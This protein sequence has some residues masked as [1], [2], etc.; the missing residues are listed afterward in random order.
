MHL[1]QGFQGFASLI[2]CLDIEIKSFW[3][4]IVEHH[5]RKIQ[6]ENNVS[7]VQFSQSC[8]IP[9]PLRKFIFRIVQKYAFHIADV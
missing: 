7:H 3:R 2:D 8:E 9:I 1:P 6:I 4:R 5:I